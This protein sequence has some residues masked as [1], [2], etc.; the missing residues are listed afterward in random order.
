MQSSPPND[1]ADD[2]KSTD[3]SAAPPANSDN[4]SNDSVAGGNGPAVDSV[5]SIRAEKWVQQGFC[6]GY[7]PL[8]H[9]GASPDDFSHDFSGDGDASGPRGFPV[10]LHGALPGETV[11]ARVTRSNN[12][13]CFALVEEVLSPAAS[14]TTSDCPAF[15]RCGGC[16]FRHIDYADEVALKLQLL[17]ELKFLRQCIDDARALERF[18]TH[19]AAPDAYRTRAR[20]HR[21]NPDAPPGFYEL[22]SNRIV[23]IPETVGCRQLAP[24]LNEAALQELVAH[25]QS[26]GGNASPSPQAPQY[27]K[28]P[29]PKR[30]HTLQLELDDPVEVDGRPWRVPGG[31]FFQANQFLLND[32]LASARSMLEPK[33]ESDLQTPADP[34]KTLELFCGS[35]LL[36][37]SLRALL[38]EYQGY[39]NSATGLKAARKNF[40]QRA[41]SGRFE[42]RDLYRRP[43]P[44]PPE[45][46]LALINPPRA[47]MNQRQIPLLAEAGVDRILYSS[48]N[49]ATLN[50]DLGKFLERGYAARAVEVFDFFPRT[51]HLEVL[52]LLEREPGTRT[53]TA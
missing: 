2:R 50:R 41:Y 11:H 10:F 52:I 25:A 18:K 47:G 35:G 49:P 42:N 27:T 39:D 16:S 5:I 13:H 17:D 9:A 33:P 15:P 6:L 8:D 43:V 23:P 29:Q 12:R 31:A 1:S 38:G 22:H 37:G 20:L 3:G 48:C 36:G 19:T 32:W 44:V 7:L 30:H 24:D 40:K 53:M 34:P 51:P 14:R 21:A 45:T 4:S 46:K 26:D 28:R